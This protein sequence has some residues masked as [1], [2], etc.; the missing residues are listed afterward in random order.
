M[1]TFILLILYIILAL[2]IIPVLLLCFILRITKPLFWYVKAAI[3]LAPKI[4]GV[5][6]HVSGRENL[7]RLKTYI[8]MA[9]HLSFM[10]GPL[11]LWLIPQH[12]RIIFKKELIWIPIIGQGMKYVQFV[13][14]DRKGK[15]GGKMAIKRATQMVMSRGFSFLIFPEGTRTRTGRMGDFHRGGFYLALESGVPIL[16][17]TIS[18]AFDLMPKG[19]FRVHKGEISV[20]FHPAIP[21][22]GYTEDGMSELMEQVRIQISS[23]LTEDEKQK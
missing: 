17:V 5:K 18:G 9:N 16:P 22:E 7:D 11:L 19:K 2:L 23:S 8:F 15:E 1:R 12:A 10:D 20:K 3:G 14:V 13:P 4:L 21:I 6:V